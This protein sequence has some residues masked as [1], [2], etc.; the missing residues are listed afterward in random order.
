MSGP[1]SPRRST[2]A[3]PRPYVVAIAIG[4]VVFALS[5]RVWESDPAIPV[6]YSRFD[7]DVPATLALVQMVAETGWYTTDPRLG[8]P[9]TFDLRDYTYIETGLFL[10]IKLMSACTKNPAYLFNGFYVLTYLLAIVTG[11]YALRRLGVSE[12][13]SIAAALLF[14]F[15]PYHFYRGMMHAS[16]SAYYPIPLVVLVCVRVIR[17][18]PLFLERD[19]GGS[20]RWRRQPGGT[21]P[22]LLSFGLVSLGGPYL[23]YFS[24]ILLASSAVIASVRRGW[25]WERFAEVGLLGT[26]MAVLFAA[27][28]RPFWSHRVRH[29]ANPTVAVRTL[30]DYDKFSLKLDAMLMPSPGH[31]IAEMRALAPLPDGGG[32]DPRK[33]F[34]KSEE[35]QGSGALGLTGSLGLLILLVVGVAAPAGRAQR[36]PLLADLA[37]LALVVLLF[38]L[39]GGFSEI[40]ALHISMAIRC[41]NRISIFLAFLSY[42]AIAILVDRSREASRKAGQRGVTFLA[43][44]A[45]ATALALLEQVPAGAVPDYRRDAAFFRGDR[46]FVERI[47]A[48]LPPGAAV[49][50]LPVLPF[51]EYVLVDRGGHAVVSGYVNFRGYFH[52]RRLRWSYG[53]MKGRE[54]AAWQESVAELPASVMVDRLGK[55]GFSGV[56]LDRS[57]YLD[58][59]DSALREIVGVLGPPTIID[60]SQDLMFFPLGRNGGRPVLPHQEQDGPGGEASRPKS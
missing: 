43:T 20:V 44:L 31:R 19:D 51:P 10:T 22:S 58:R 49:F 37:R 47:E 57:S 8:A 21:V 1:A 39:H 2:L 33:A 4:S 12:S 9:G 13:A 56:Y 55:A 29:G 3:G 28:A 38:A 32:G 24:G 27:Q 46:A 53:A 59:G 18:E 42:A 17:G 45:V 6:D 40:I 11:V 7:S 15:T 34:I 5:L 54:V 48:S 52:S 25:R 36:M 26:L 41:Y 35:T 30:Q 23:A 50:Q 16:F 60:A 14:A